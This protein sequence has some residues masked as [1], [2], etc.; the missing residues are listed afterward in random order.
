MPMVEAISAGVA[1]AVAAL[2]AMLDRI[3]DPS[4]PAR[5]Q[6]LTPSLVL[7]ESCGAY[8]PRKGAKAN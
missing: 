2:R 3:S 5:S 1:M 7:R 6:L 4:L 8:R